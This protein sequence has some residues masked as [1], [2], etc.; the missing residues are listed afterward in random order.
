MPILNAD[1]A[2][3]IIVLKRSMAPGFAGVENEL[4]YNPKTG[5]LFGDARD[6]RLKLIGEI[7]NL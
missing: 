7:Q 5:M 4:F 2:K 6:S 3:S 1:Q